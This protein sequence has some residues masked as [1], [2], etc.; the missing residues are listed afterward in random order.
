MCDLPAPSKCDESEIFRLYTKQ[1]KSTMKQTLSVPPQFFILYYSVTIRNLR[2]MYKLS[3][4]LVELSANQFRIS[5]KNI[6]R[7]AQ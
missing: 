6:R 1:I 4:F 5:K 7:H 3:T 2:N